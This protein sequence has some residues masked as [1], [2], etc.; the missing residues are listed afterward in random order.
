MKRAPGGGVDGCATFWKKDL[1]RQ[2]G[3]PMVVEFTQ[4][5]LGRNDFDKN[6]TMFDR[7]CGK[8]NIALGVVLEV[9][10]SEPKDA[11]PFRFLVTNVHIHWDPAQTDVKLVQAVML[12]DE[13]GKFSKKFLDEHPETVR[14]GSTI[15]T[16]ICGD[17]N[18]LPGGLVYDFLS[19]PGGVRDIG[20]H[21][22]LAECFT[23]ETS[24]NAEDPSSA[25]TDASETTTTKKPS[26][27]QSAASLSSIDDDS[28]TKLRRWRNWKESGYGE[29]AKSEVLKHTMSGSLRSAYSGIEGVP[30]E[31]SFI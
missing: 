20:K 1:F 2:V 17:F 31:V 22:D 9:I 23:V 4:L 21:P 11:V 19:N 13:I 8:D 12:M 10:E 28:R 15:P 5:A 14:G 16:I 26:V 18:S 27:V 30:V 25:S 3:S 7:F 29:I 24:E 6:D